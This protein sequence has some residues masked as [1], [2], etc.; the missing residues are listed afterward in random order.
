MT[1]R[2]RSRRLEEA[3]LLA[4]LERG[5]TSVIPPN[6]LVLAWRWRYELIVL[7]G[8]PAGMIAEAHAV[9]WRWTLIELGLAAGNLCVWHE[10]R[11]WIMAH[12][13][14]VITAHRLRTGCAQSW[15]HSRRGR[16]PV[17]LWTAPRAS[18]ERAYVW[19][20]AGTSVEDFEFARDLLRSACWAHDVRVTRS[21]RYSHVVIVEVI[22]GPRPRSS[23]GGHPQDP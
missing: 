7:T 13:R 3:R 6:P 23:A 12:I 14:C 15:I 20:R 10:A 17:I 9:G 5:F 21:V 11:R 1:T 4:G 16:L 2:R 18:G 19:C 22:R 8:M